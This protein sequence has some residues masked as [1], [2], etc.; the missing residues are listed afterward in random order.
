MSEIDE[1][2]SPT[3]KVVREGRDIGGERIF[4]IERK[5]GATCWIWEHERENL[6]RLQEAQ[7]DDRLR[8]I[9]HTPGRREPYVDTRNDVG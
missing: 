1:Q 5:Q 6:L 4:R 7:R 2:L 9:L 8:Q 3:M